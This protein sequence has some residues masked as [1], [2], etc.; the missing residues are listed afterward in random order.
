MVSL[1]RKISV[2]VLIYLVMHFAPVETRSGSFGLLKPANR[3]E[4]AKAKAL[5]AAMKIY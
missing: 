3:D 5:F 4:G 1:P 2:P